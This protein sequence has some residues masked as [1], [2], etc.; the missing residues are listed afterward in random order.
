MLS[1]AQLSEM[2]PCW[3]CSKCSLVCFI[4]QLWVL[5]DSSLA[6]TVIGRSLKMPHTS[7]VIPLSHAG[8]VNVVF[9]NPDQKS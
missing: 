8:I 4:S 9:K 3:I 2:I 6:E 5:L 7:V 1:A